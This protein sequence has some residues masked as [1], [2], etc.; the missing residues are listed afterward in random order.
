MF[1]FDTYMLSLCGLC[2]CVRVDCI[3]SSDHL[4]KQMRKHARINTHSIKTYCKNSDTLCTPFSLRG[5]FP[6]SS[7]HHRPRLHK[8]IVPAHTPG[9]LDELSGPILK[10][11]K[12]RVVSTVGY[13][14]IFLQFAHRKCCLD[15]G[16]GFEGP[17]T[18]IQYL[19]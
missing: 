15:Q 1:S 2:L 10:E 16:H 6:L 5:N 12:S 17:G 13:L 8:C 11:G 19:K 14:R 4:V 7:S 9:F 18:C 3:S